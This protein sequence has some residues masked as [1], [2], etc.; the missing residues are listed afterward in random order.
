MC[1]QWLVY[2][3]QIEATY[4]FIYAIIKCTCRSFSKHM[5]SIKTLF[6]LI[7]RISSIYSFELSF[8]CPAWIWLHSLRLGWFS[9]TCPHAFGP[10]HYQAEHSFVLLPGHILFSRVGL[11]WDFEI[12]HVSIM[13]AIKKDNPVISGN[14]PDIWLLPHILYCWPPWT[15]TCI[16]S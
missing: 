9:L 11:S 2:Y 4:T 7:G 10:G 6:F 15:F 3:M 16:P 8:S 14:H 5:G 1:W 13:E 12:L